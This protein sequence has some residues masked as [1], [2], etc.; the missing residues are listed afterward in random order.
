MRDILVLREARGKKL[1]QMEGLLTAAG[2]NDLTDEQIKEFDDLKAEIGKMDEQIKRLEAVQ[3][4][5][6]AQAKPVAAEVPV[7]RASVPATAKAPKQKGAD[8]SRCIAALAAT[9]G[10][11]RDAAA[12]AEKTWG[13]DAADVS[14]ALGVSSGSTGG[15]LVPTAMSS[16][17]IELLRPEAV[18]LALN[19]VIYEMPSGNMTIPGAASGASASYVGENANITNSAPSVRQ[20]RLTAK[21]LGV[22]V[23]MSNDM[24][25]YPSV[26]VDNFVRS[27]LL[28][29]MAE[30]ADLAM[31]RGN[32]SEHTPRGLKSF[33]EATSAT[34]VIA[35]NGTVN[36]T[37]VIDDLGKLRL[38][39]VNGNV[40][41]RQP[42]MII[43]PRVEQYLMNLVNGLN[44]Y[45]FRD[46]MLGRGT[47]NG[48][49]Y[50]RTTQIP[51]NLGGGTE[52]EVY[53]ADF[54][55]VIYGDAMTLE[56]ETFPGGAY[57]DASGNMISGISQ[58]QQVIR[59]TVQHDFAVRQ[60]RAVAMLT[61]VTWG[62]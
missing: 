62:A 12:W 3:S 47:I 56:I 46:E 15:F 57:I 35:A 49:P 9:K 41:M 20:I 18:V 39:L 7:A 11:P 21:K 38:A 44:L 48:I 1:D 33:A 52:S 10:H 14:K 50:K 37:N 23:A 22:T 43:A 27:D 5:K 28:G 60:D 29:A 24:L 45:A 61:G 51:T 6:A 32:G 55:E 16:E 31:I 54:S 26:N 17:F 42:G 19:P 34:Q 2:E 30:T 53:L 8:L 13:D 40:R 4:M 36:Y 58:D 25:R 59:A